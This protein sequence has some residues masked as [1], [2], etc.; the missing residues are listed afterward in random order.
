MQVSDYADRLLANGIDCPFRVLISDTV[1]QRRPSEP[2]AH[3]RAPP[4]Q[5][6]NHG[7]SDNQIKHLFVGRT[8]AREDEDR[9]AYHSERPYRTG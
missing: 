3:A 8:Y 2:I 4:E 6:Q 7:H 5:K 1:V 9:S